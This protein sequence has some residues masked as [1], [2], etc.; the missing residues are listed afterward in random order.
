MQ[1]WTNLPWPDD[2]YR[3]GQQLYRRPAPRLAAFTTWPTVA[4]GQVVPLTT[5]IVYL[6][7]DRSKPVAVTGQ[8]L[9][10]GFRAVSVGDP[11]ELP[12]VAEVADLD[13][14]QARRHAAILAGYHLGQDLAALRQAEGTTARR[15]LAAVA[16]NWAD[17]SPAAG[18]A[19]LVD[20]DL[21]L[22]GAGLPLGQACQQAGISPTA[23]G[24]VGQGT[25][26]PATLA[27]KR[28]LVI[29]LLCASHHG[30]YEWDGILDT[31]EAMAA[32]TWDCLPWPETTARTVLAGDGNRPP[33]GGD[34]DLPTAAGQ[35]Q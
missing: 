24:A 22:S 9:A 33:G 13:L 19:A 23:T 15:G 10:F 11:A 25:S 17:R 28:A 1:T 14:M 3:T 30:R 34:T 31:G 2:P 4:G 5:A 32:S 7:L 35:R 12:A 27:V 8:T 16:D 21:D 20:C 6:P 18:R 29:A 26:H